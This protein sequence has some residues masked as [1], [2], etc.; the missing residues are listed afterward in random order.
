MKAGDV[1]ILSDSR[2]CRV[3]DLDNEIAGL[4]DVSTVQ[5]INRNQE[6][7]IPLRVLKEGE[8]LGQEPEVVASF[9]STWSLHVRMNNMGAL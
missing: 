3:I 1:L 2:M 6:T 7:K 4:P 8:N 9:Y 5:F